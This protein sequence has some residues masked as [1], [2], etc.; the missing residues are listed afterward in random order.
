[1]SPPVFLV[2][3]Q[4]LD[5]VAG[6]RIV[7]DGAEGRHAVTVRRLR[8]G[9]PVEL[10]DGAGTRAHGVVAEVAGRDQLT[11]EV[12]R[13]H[14]EPPPQPRV[15]VV[16]ALPKGDRGETAVETLTEVGADVIV[17][18]AAAR[19]VARW[20]VQRAERG[21]ARWRASA[22]EASKQARRARVPEVTG[23]ASTAEV[24]QLLRSARLGLVL[25]ESA[26]L[27]LAAMRLPEAGDVVIV[28]GPEGGID[29]D[30]LAGFV[31][32]GGLAVRLGPTVL[33]TSTAGT[34]AAAVVLAATGRWT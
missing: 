32:A 17:P 7:L 5:S 4:V 18:W 2:A 15:V 28:V 31:A 25:H 9:E 30:E 10:V 1:M 6:G 8:V 3:P 24:D 33:R 13:V 12:G 19:S 23:V 29:D 21:L 26:A 16:Q 20:D 11:V 14:H 27:R 34:A 22:R